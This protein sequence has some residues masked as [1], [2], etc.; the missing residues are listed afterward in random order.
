MTSRPAAAAAPSPMTVSSMV[1]PLAVVTGDIGR[2]L[3]LG[4]RSPCGELEA[5]LQR[6]GRQKVRER[7]Q[8]SYKYLRNP[9]TPPVPAPT[10]PGR[11]L[12]LFSSSPMLPAATPP[13]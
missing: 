13:A 2:F 5:V 1:R 6:S 10:F 11:F 3:R 9:R 7:A 12:S 4:Q 8:I